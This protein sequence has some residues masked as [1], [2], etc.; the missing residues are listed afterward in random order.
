MTDDSAGTRW[1]AA[2]RHPRY[3]PTLEE[4]D[5]R[6]TGGPSAHARAPNRPSVR[7]A[8]GIAAACTRARRRRRRL[9]SASSRS[10]VIT[11]RPSV[12]QSRSRY[13]R[14]ICLL[15][16]LSD[17]RCRCRRFAR[18][19]ARRNLSAETGVRYSLVAFGVTRVTKFVGRLKR[20]DGRLT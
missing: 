1:V 20:I 9:R 19:R 12:H 3:R 18:A 17:R 6:P 11:G 2:G 10:E 4:Q 8:R 16:I 5:D 13:R 7:V 14:A 15:R